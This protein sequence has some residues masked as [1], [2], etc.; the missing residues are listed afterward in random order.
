MASPYE[1]CLTCCWV[2]TADRWRSHTCSTHSRHITTCMY[3]S[4]L[5]CCQTLPLSLPPMITS[6]THRITHGCDM[7]PQITY[8]SPAGWRHDVTYVGVAV[9]GS[10][11]SP[12]QL[13]LFK[14]Y[15]NQL[16]SQ[17]QIYTPEIHF[18]RRWRCL[19][20]S[21]LYLLNFG[22]PLFKLW[23][24]TTAAC[25]ACRCAA[26]LTPGQCASLGYQWRCHLDAPPPTTSL[27]C[28]FCQGSSSIN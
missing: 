28:Y 12:R 11:W 22:L 10:V 15:K 24:C 18:I 2:Y 1:G 19:S 27:S 4:C 9:W 3:A 6:N 7:M 17:A 13:L 21:N 16:L 26:S 23:W 14:I 8:T 25:P 20:H 5:H